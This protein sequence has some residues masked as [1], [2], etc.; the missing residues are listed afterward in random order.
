M[1]NA[2]GIKRPSDA[3]EWIQM[4]FPELGGLPGGFR[5]YKHGIGCAVRGPDWSVDFDFGEH[6]E[7]DGF[8]AYRLYDFASK[9]LSHYG[10]LVCRRDRTVG[11]GG[12]QRRRPVVLGLHPLLPASD[13]ADD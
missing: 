12:T 1:L 2:A 9:R 6:G 13:R 7:I 4:E 3:Q 5:Y 8:D 10:F 11:E